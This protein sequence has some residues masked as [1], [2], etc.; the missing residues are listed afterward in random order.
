MSSIEYINSVILNDSAASISFTDIP[1]NY[2]D[3]KLV[4][5][6]NKSAAD[7]G[8]WFRLNGNTET[9]Y[10][11]TNLSGNGSSAI[12]GRDSNT[13]VGRYF[14]GLSNATSNNFFIMDIFSYAKT[15][16]FKTAITVASIASVGTETNVNLWR[17]TAA[18]NSI[19]L[20]TLTGSYSAG[21]I[22]T[23]WGIK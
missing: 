19:S 18:I 11:T 1:Q 8:S 6:F 9:N 10:S 20:I 23:L 14:R 15:D 22:A 5:F 3:L 13:D 16:F 7:T 17:Q 12:S 21:S 2:N 4:V